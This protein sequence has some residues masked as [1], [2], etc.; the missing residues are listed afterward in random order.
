MGLT[1]EQRRALRV[2]ADAEPE[3]ATQAM[4][5]AHGFQAADRNRF[6]QSG[7][8]RCT[9]RG[10]RPSAGVGQTGLLSKSA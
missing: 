4:L 10:G 9:Y 1:A 8:R 6:G 5:E 3:G 2:I 7:F